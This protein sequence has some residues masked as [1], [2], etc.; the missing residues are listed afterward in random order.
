MSKDY[1]EDQLIEQPCMDVFQSLG[2]E[3]ANVF[4]GE[5]FGEHGT[6]GRD[7]EADVILR[8]RFYK[9]IKNLNPNLPK[10]AYDLSGLRLRQNLLDPHR[11]QESDRLVF[12]KNIQ[13]K[14]YI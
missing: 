7:S 3:V 14:R 6:L 11:N 13:R 10:Q 12:D 2:W 8:T 5:T 9:A 1:S 4:K